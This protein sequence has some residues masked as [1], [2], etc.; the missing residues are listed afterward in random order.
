VLG[1]IG[2]TDAE[3]RLYRTLIRLG[4]ATVEELTITDRTTLAGLEEKGLAS[5]AAGPGE[6]FVPAP[7]DVAIEALAARRHE[8]LA[9]ARLAGSEL[10]DEFRAGPGPAR[11][12]EVL[13]VVTGCDAVRSRFQQLQRGAASELLV[14]DKP[15][16]TTAPADNEPTERDLLARGVRYRVVYDRTSLAEPGQPARLEAL[17]AAGQEARLCT[18]LPM[19]LVIAD[20]RL[21]LTPL[22]RHHGLTD[23]ALL[24]HESALLDVLVALF[25]GVWLRAVPVP[26]AAGEDD[27][28]G[29]LLL[30]LASG[31]KDAAIARQLGLGERTVRRRVAALAVR[32]GARTRFQLGVQ[33]ARRGW[34]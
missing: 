22:S 5:R 7:P 16:Y 3:E 28:D 29:R 32:L 13:E 17:T 26:E 33:A 9:R 2:V 8:E 11:A 21:A 12:A 31:L 24:V 27:E 23:A 25:D 19:K 4:G 6:R 1:G 15:P 30:M 14:F 18:A 34:L 20:R 10:M